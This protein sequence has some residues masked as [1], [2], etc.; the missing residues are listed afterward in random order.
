MK[1]I[2]AIA[3]LSFGLASLLPLSA[4]QAQRVH[5]LPAKSAVSALAEWRL[6]WWDGVDA[7]ALE[8]V[9]RRAA[10]LMTCDGCI[11]ENARRVT[12]ISASKS[13]L[14]THNSRVHVWVSGDVKYESYNILKQDGQ[15]IRARGRLADLV[16]EENSRDDWELLIPVSLEVGS[17]GVTLTMKPRDA[18]NWG[19]SGKIGDLFTRQVERGVRQARPITVAWD[20]KSHQRLAEIFRSFGSCR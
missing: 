5:Q 13:K 15:R 10:G 8:T 1:K 6:S 19:L 16:Y 9:K 18:D 2:S 4:A 11:F 7:H 14:C 12:H 17:R 3:A 20:G